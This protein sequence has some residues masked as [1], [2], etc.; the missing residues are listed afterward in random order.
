MLRL[1]KS[2]ALI[3]VA[4]LIAAP[5]ASAQGTS[6]RTIRVVVPFPPGAG[7][8]ALPRIVLPAALKV[9]GEK[10]IVENRV[11]FSGNLGTAYVAGAKPDGLTLLLGG[12]WLST[13]GTLY[14]NAKFDT[15]RDFDPVIL[16]ATLPLVMV[17]NPAIPVKT[18]EEFIAHAK[19]NPK[20]LNFGSSGAGS[21]PY[22]VAELFKRETHTE[23]THIAYKGI[24]QAL[25]DVVAGHLDIVFLG[26]SS[27]KP[28]IDSGKLRALAATG[29][30]R[31]SVL[32]DVPT[33]T[34]KGITISGLDIGAWWGILAPTGTPRATINALNHAFNEALKDDE[35]RQRLAV[36]GFTPKGGS[37]EEFDKLIKAETATWSRLIADLNIKAE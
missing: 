5:T 13:N 18:L 21:Q 30:Q 28:F 14:S 10:G 1:T 37:V 8:D 35:T 29:L 4:C 6:E 32:P 2:T 23:L 20:K 22:L 17:I 7:T 19:K 25:T 33:F 34:E 27:T 11:G 31:V 15:A 9:L 36:G 24:G 3:A 12:I 16:L 26:S